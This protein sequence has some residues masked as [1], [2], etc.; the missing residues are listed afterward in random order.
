MMRRKDTASIQR[1]MI[2]S[3]RLIPADIPSLESSNGLCIVQTLTISKPLS[4][5][6]REDDSYELTAEQQMMLDRGLLEPESCTLQTC[7]NHVA[8]CRRN[9]GRCS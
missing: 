7:A 8:C 6:C 4:F 9:A 5:L 3:Q 1:V 2:A